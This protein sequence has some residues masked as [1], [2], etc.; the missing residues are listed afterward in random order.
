MSGFGNSGGFGGQQPPPFGQQHGFGGGFGTGS[1]QPPPAFAGGGFG[2]SAPGFGFGTQTSANTSFG[3]SNN[4]S[5]FAQAPSPALFGSSPV[6]FANAMATP[7]GTT[8]PPPA[9]GMNATAPAFNPSAF[10]STTMQPPNRFGAPAQSAVTQ[11]TFPAFGANSSVTTFGSSNA[12]TNFSSTPF[13]TT[14]AASAGFGINAGPA[15][16]GGFGTTSSFST[17]PPFSTAPSSH[18]NVTSFQASPFGSTLAAPAP[19][20]MFGASSTIAPAPPSQLPFPVQGFHNDNHQQ[21]YPNRFGSTPFGATV[22]PAFGSATSGPAVFGS[23][24][25]AAFGTFGSRASNFDPSAASF[26][27][28]GVGS[29]PFGADQQVYDESMGDGGGSA[30]DQPSDVGLQA[31]SFPFGQKQQQFTSFGGGPMMTAIAE[32]S[33]LQ[34]ASMED[35]APDKRAQEDKLAALKAKLAQKK[36]KLEEGKQ[37][38]RKQD[39]ITPPPPSTTPESTL[40]AVASESPKSSLAERN[41]LRFAPKANSNTRSQL[42]VGL[43]AAPVVKKPVISSAQEEKLHTQL[44][45]EDAVALVG[46]CQHMCPDQEL[47]QREQEGDIQLLETPQPGTIH[48]P[49]WNLRNTAVKRF[50]RSAADYKLDIPELVRP[51]DVLERTCSYLEEWVMVSGVYMAC[52]FNL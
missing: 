15:S 29:T 35:P 18:S 52:F 21:S 10:G 25:P 8:A 12:T 4:S 31:S 37:K 7:F 50:R 44:D 38:Q 28:P 6:G 49:D 42:P 17:N 22:P 41:A 34:E 36:K 30:W 1:S 23:A 14:S 13:G 43:D 2:N 33:G 24:A 27:A 16:G 19:A 5:S 51:P 3:S 20:L 47:R 48:P 9:S 46:I 40:E 32:Q 26:V 11:P 45:L 39:S